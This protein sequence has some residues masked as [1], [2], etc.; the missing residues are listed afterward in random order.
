MTTSILL[1]VGG[2]LADSDMI[3]HNWEKVKHYFYFFRKFFLGLLTG[4]GLF[5]KAPFC[6]TITRHMQNL[7]LR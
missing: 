3:P 6:A 2:S 4:F 5:S 1:H 7:N